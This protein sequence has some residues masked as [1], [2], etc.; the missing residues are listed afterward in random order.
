MNAAGK[1]VAKKMFGEYGIYCDEIIVALVCDNGLFVKPTDNG[2]K[3]IGVVD[4]APAYPGS[5]MYFR[6]G[7]KINDYEWLSELIKISVAELKKSIKSKKSKTRN[8]NC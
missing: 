5:K 6:I 7:D 2:R 4:E 1:I 3:F 8:K